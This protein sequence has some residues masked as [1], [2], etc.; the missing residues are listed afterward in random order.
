VLAYGLYRFAM[1]SQATRVRRLWLTANARLFRAAALGVALAASTPALIGCSSSEIENDGSIRGTLKVYVATMD[2]GTTRTEYKI[3][4]G[5]NELD[6]RLLVFA[7]P[8][9]AVGEREIKVWGDASG[10][11]IIVNRYEFV[12]SDADLGRSQEA[13]IGGTP[14]PSRSF[15]YVLVNIGGGNGS[16]TTAQAEIDLFGTGASD[17]STK[18]WFLENSYGRQDIG[19]DVV[20]PLSAS[21][22]G[23]NYSSIPSALRSQ[24]NDALGTTPQNYL[25]YFLTRN[26]SCSWAGLASVGNPMTPARDTWYNASSSCVVLVQEPA[27]NFGMQ[28]S[29]SLRCGSSSFANDPSTCTHDEYGDPHDPM[30]GGCRHTNAWQKAYQGWFGGCNRLKVGQSGTY[31]LL[32]LENACNGIQV[33]QIPMPAN[34]QRRIPRSGGGGQA[35]NDLVNFYYLEL[36]TRTGFDQSAMTFPT[37]LVHVGP[38]VRTR[39]QTG[40]HTWILDMQPS[41]TGRGSWDGMAAGQTFMDPA[42]GVSFTVQSLSATGAVINVTLPDGMGGTNTCADGGTLST[43]TGPTDCGSGGVGGAGGMAGMGGMGG[44]GG[45]GGM[46]GRAG[47]GGMGGRAGAGGMGGAGGLAGG[48]GGIAGS[49]GAAGFGG[50]AGGGAGGIA[51][52]PATGG[53][54]GVPVAGTAGISGS[55]GSGAG[56]AGAATGGGAGRGPMPPDPGD[57][58]PGCGC[59]VDKAPQNNEATLLFGLLGLV[60]AGVAR[61]RTRRS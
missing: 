32:P 31:N 5:D 7:K 26:S 22:S 42:G 17:G 27:H 50:L 57:L 6:E 25:W 60:A 34:P 45:A 52:S 61:R 44:R 16:Y 40:L 55:A 11:E 29:S 36:R 59:R 13:I 33:L 54:A 30:G 47:A 37:V 51:G 46:G 9:E 41:S 49:A 56:T 14:Y 10:R 53:T 19:G 24:V 1:Q 18:Q 38:E 23:C 58:D 43:P 12:E 15:A 3:L 35:S 20:G 28:H 48:S 2:D 4:V 8:P 21:M 39:T